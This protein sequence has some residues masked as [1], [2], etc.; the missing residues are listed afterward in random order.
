MLEGVVKVAPRGHVRLAEAGQVRS[1]DVKPV[2]EQRD[3]LAKHVARGRE[4]VQQ[5]ERRRVRCSGLPVEHRQAIH[6]CRAICGFGHESSLIA[7][8]PPHTVR[9]NGAAVTWPGTRD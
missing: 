4:A 1:N 5:Q 2:G 8:T 3:Q 6:F 7:A 9:V